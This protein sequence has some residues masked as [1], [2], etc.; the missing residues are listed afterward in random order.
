LR[1]SFPPKDRVAPANA[2]ESGRSVIRPKP[3]PL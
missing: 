3:K 2:A 1:A